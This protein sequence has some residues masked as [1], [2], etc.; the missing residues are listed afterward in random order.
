MKSHITATIDQDLVRRLDRHSSQEKRS[1]SQTLELALE[2]FLESKAKPG[3]GLMITQGR[4][5]EQVD[6]ADCYVR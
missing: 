2:S 4:F 1:R 3:E 5:L 6:R